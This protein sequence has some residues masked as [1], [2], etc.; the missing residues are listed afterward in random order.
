MKESCNW[1][2]LIWTFNSVLPWMNRLEFYGY[3]NRVYGLIHRSPNERMYLPS[4]AVT[5]FRKLELC[6]TVIQ[7]PRWCNPHHSAQNSNFVPM[8]IK[9][10]CGGGG[11][12]YLWFQWINLIQ[13]PEIFSESGSV[14]IFIK[15]ITVDFCYLYLNLPRLLIMIKSGFPLESL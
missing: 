7:L 4:I 12:S 13:N 8:M 1:N 3:L 5:L 11:I 15:N 14:L 6:W 10:V 9:C 2:F